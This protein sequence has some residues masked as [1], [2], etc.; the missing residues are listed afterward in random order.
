[1]GIWDQNNQKFQ[2]S[3]KKSGDQICVLFH[4]PGSKLA[5]RGSKVRKTDFFGKTHFFNWGTNCSHTMYKMFL[6]KNRGQMK[7]FTKKMFVTLR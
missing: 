5:Y 3:L 7:K 6:K 2:K 4:N 1:M